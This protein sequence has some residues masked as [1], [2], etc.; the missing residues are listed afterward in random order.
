MEVENCD[1]GRGKGINE[2]L[3]REGLCAEDQTQD[4]KNKN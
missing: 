4:L 2:R 3:G 1:K